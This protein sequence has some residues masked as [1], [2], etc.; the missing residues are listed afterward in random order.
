VWMRNAPGFGGG[1]IKKLPLRTQ[2]VI[3]GISQPRDDLQWWPVRVADD[4]GFVAQADKFSTVL[5]GAA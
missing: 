2:V 5:L 4:S 3:T 1:K